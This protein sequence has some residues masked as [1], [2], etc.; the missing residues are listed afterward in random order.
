MM[1]IGQV[2]ASQ[3]DG[4]RDWTLRLLADVRGDDW[5][6]QPASGL[7]HA[8]WLCGHIAV[9]Q[10]VLIHVRCLGKGVVDPAFAAKFPMGGPVAAVSGGAYPSPEEALAV[11]RDTHE[12][13]L[14]AVRGMSEA[15]LAEPAFG[16][17]GA[18]H[19]HYRDKLG[20]VSHC[21]RHE[22]FHAGQLATLRRMIGKPF[23]R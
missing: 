2:L 11:M 7:P 18:I 15:L 8:L 10:D 9:S 21:D 5:A 1:N 3:L 16:K 6:F 12:K 22:A 4:T 14:A 23:L 17:D 19:P 13:T 20:A